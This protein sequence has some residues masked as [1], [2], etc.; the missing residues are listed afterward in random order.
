MS[1]TKHVEIYFKKTLGETLLLTGIGVGEFPLES[2]FSTESRFF[3]NGM[4]SVYNDLFNA[5]RPLSIEL[6]NDKI[7]PF[8]YATHKI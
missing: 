1:T 4:H 7:T 3:C 5:I 6:L 8:M 2:H